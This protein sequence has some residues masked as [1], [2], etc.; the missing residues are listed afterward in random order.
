MRSTRT[1]RKDIFGT[2]VSYANLHDPAVLDLVHNSFHR[3]RGKDQTDC[4]GAEEERIEA[5]VWLLPEGISPAS[6][7]ELRQKYKLHPARVF[8]SCFLQVVDKR[9]RCENNE[10]DLNPH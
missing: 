9:I 5:V 3:N 6:N 8:T 7:A 2:L 1:G 10:V 4:H